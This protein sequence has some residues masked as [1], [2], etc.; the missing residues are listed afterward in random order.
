MQNKK[1][2]SDF[3]IFDI[4]NKIIGHTGIAC[5]SNYDA[6]SL[7]NLELVHDLLVGW[8]RKLVA[9]VNEYHDAKEY[10]AQR[11]VARQKEI[12]ADLRDW[13]KDVEEYLNGE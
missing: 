4:T 9:D 12:L 5:E 3:T 6:E 11:V 13:I 7:K 2:Q 1:V 10:S 8:V